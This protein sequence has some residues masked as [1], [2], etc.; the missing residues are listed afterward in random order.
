[1]PLR[2]RAVVT[3]KRTAARSSRPDGDLSQSHDLDRSV[4]ELLQETRVATAG[5]QFLFAFLL[6]LPFTQRFGSL[7]RFDITVYTVTLLSTACAALVLIAPVPFH[8]VLFRQ[9]EKDAVVTFADHVLL[10]GLVLL[11]IAIAGAVLLVLDVV[12]G[13]GPAVAGSAVVAVLGAVVWFAVPGRHRARSQ[14]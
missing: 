1:V 10:A 6:T 11:L 14:D 9:H 12:L 5:V 4:S 7:S 2:Y 8:R 3:G 13:R